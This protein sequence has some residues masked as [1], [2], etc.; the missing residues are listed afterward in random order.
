LVTGLAFIALL[1]VTLITRL[2]F[3]AERTGGTGS[4]A[5]FE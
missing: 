3:L 5:F 4:D 2:T 1:P